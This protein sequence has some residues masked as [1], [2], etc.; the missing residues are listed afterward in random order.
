MPLSQQHV[1]AARHSRRK[2]APYSPPPSAQFGI[3]YT[4]S[5]GYRLGL[6]LNDFTGA[7]YSELPTQS[8][9][10]WVLCLGGAV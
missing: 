10:K 1:P 2:L 8:N 5:I 6:R 7:M 4:C 3:P 9:S